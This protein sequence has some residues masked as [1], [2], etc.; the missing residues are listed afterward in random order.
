MGAADVL[1]ARRNTVSE[2]FGG[3]RVLTEL[4][5]PETDFPNWI[6]P[7]ECTIILSSARVRRASN[8]DLYWATRPK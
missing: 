1:I 7:D 2:S 4:N 6:S 3:T 5:S 8:Y